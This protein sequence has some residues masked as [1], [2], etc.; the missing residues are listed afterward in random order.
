MLNHS[1]AALLSFTLIFCI[2]F[3]VTRKKAGALH[4]D[5]MQLQIRG[6]AYKLG[7]S[8]VIVLLAVTGLLY[9]ADGLNIS[10]YMTTDMLLFVILYAGVTVFAVYS[11]LNNAF[12]RVLENGNRYLLL[13]VF[14]IV[15]NGASLF[16]SIRSGCRR[17]NLQSFAVCPGRRSAQ[18]KRETI[19]QAFTYASQSA[20]HWIKHW[21]IYSGRKNRTD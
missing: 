3:L 4:Y 12:F 16:Q 21:M 20:R 18:L 9:D 1:F 19:I 15:S 17:K 11:I 8:A 7:F 5:E 10:N 2:I 6:D 13:C 14:L